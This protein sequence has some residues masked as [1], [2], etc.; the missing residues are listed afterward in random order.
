MLQNALAHRPNKGS[1]HLEL[2]VDEDK[3]PRPLVLSLLHLWK[4]G[5]VMAWQSGTGLQRL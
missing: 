3:L 2:G 4:E 1:F 5:G